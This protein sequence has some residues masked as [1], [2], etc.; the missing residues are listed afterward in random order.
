MPLFFIR[1]SILTIR[2]Y[3]CGLIPSHGGFGLPY[4]NFRAHKHSVHR[5]EWHR[6]EYL[7]VNI[8]SVATLHAFKYSSIKY[9]RFLKKLQQNQRLSAEEQTSSFVPL[10]RIT[11]QQ[12]GTVVVRQS[13]SA[14][15]SLC[16]QSTPLAS[17]MPALSPLMS[18]QEL[19]E[20]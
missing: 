17:V 15:L 12:P 9:L 2:L 16:T 1:A 18:S 7:N 8:F 20:Q 11:C 4:V 3:P 19:T 5:Y 14:V 6:P 13:L 10:H